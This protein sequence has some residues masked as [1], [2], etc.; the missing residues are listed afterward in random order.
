[1]CAWAHGQLWVWSTG[2]INTKCNISWPVSPISNK[3]KSC[4]VWAHLQFA[5]MPKSRD[6][7][8]FVL[9]VMTD[10]LKKCSGH[11]WN[12]WFLAISW[13]FWTTKANEHSSTGWHQTFAKC[14]EKGL[15]YFGPLFLWLVVHLVVQLVLITVCRSGVVWLKVPVYFCKGENLLSS[16]WN[17][18][19]FI[20]I[21][22]CPLRTCQRASG[23]MPKL[24]NKTKS[25]QQIWP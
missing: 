24:E 7:V 4:T 15:P 25:T 8:I 19:L 6:L 22:C 9:T 17:Y 21:H 11:T 18:V 14:L 13:K 20:M 5:L 2:M 1:M 12:L 10:K 23:Y 16:Q 3:P